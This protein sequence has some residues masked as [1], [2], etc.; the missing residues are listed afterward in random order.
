[1]SKANNQ[2]GELSK[3]QFSEL[4]E[5][6]IAYLRKIKSEDVHVYFPQ[7]PEINAGLTLFVLLS[8]KGAPLILTDS[9]SVAMENA[10]T[11][12]LKMVSVH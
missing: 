11:N 9:R 5:G 12:D 2:T 3:K 10:S 1:M 4:G 7:I 8:A 6:A